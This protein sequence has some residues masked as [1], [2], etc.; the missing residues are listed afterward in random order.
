MGPFYDIK[1]LTIGIYQYPLLVQYIYFQ[2][3]N[4][5]VL[6]KGYLLHKNK[7]CCVVILDETPPN[8]SSVAWNGIG[9]VSDDLDDRRQVFQQCTLLT[10]STIH[11]PGMSHCIRALFQN[12]TVVELHAVQQFLLHAQAQVGTLYSSS[13]TQCYRSG[14]PC[15]PTSFQPCR[16]HPQCAS[17]LR[18]G[19]FGGRIRHHGDVSFAPSEYL[20]ST[21]EQDLRQSGTITEEKDLRRSSEYA[22]R[23]PVPVGMTNPQTTLNVS[24]KDAMSRLAHNNNDIESARVLCNAFRL[25]G[26]ARDEQ[27][28]R[29]Y[30]I[31]LVRLQKISC[32][33]MVAGMRCV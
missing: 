22:S 24:I 31:R 14:V 28:C 16:K 18:G 9:Q 30:L 21:E 33:T 19:S 29:K 4:V 5:T 7:S 17:S 15:E 3:A 23:E 10:L 1:Y 13:A 26:E 27:R 8:F 32:H 11:L 2:Y 12:D 20:W 25:H 6:Q